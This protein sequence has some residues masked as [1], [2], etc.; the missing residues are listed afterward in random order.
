MTDK[1]KSTGK[2]SEV[3][4]GQENSSIL[5]DKKGNTDHPYPQPGKDDK[6]YK[7]QEEFTEQFPNKRA[8][9]ED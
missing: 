3:R 1:N 7:N 8:E 6:R 4:E 2:S 9:E 5:H